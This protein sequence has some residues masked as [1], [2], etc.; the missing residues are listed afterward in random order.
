V[1]ATRFI[2][3]PDQGDAQVVVL[4]AELHEEAVSIVLVTTIGDELAAGG[5]YD[6]DEP[7]LTIEDDV[8]TEYRHAPQLGLGTIGPGWHGSHGVSRSNVEYEPAVPPEA[9]RLRVRL[10]RRGSVV[11]TI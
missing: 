7:G 11:L 6:P 5:F 1:A 9:T 10:G 3:A 4:A 2:P 8:G